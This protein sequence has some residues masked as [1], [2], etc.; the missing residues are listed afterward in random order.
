[1]ISPPLQGLT[2]WT[3]QSPPSLP[4]VCNSW[5]TI[6]PPKAKCLISPVRRSTLRPDLP[7][8]NEAL[9]GQDTLPRSREFATRGHPAPSAPSTKPTTPSHNLR[10]E[11]SD[12]PLRGGQGGATPPIICQ[13]GILSL[14]IAIPVLQIRIPICQTVIPLVQI[15]ILLLRIRIP[16][17]H[18]R[19]LP[20]HSR[21]LP[22]HSRIPS[23]HSRIL[24]HHFR[25]PPDHFPILQDQ[26]A[27]HLPQYPRA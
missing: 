23:D 10:S 11:R 24:P 22:D 15:H 7:E 4:R 13:T 20:D 26:K 25:I 8:S 1:V 16:P 9:L 6:H 18:F 14:Q 17:D 12:P 19:I 3:Q 2:T 5:P 21:I 27:H